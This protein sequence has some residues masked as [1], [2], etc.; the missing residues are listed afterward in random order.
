MS[1]AVIS[2]LEGEICK[3]NGCNGIMSRPFG[4]GHRQ[5]GAWVLHF[6][7]GMKNGKKLRNKKK[8]RKGNNICM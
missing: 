7:V 4:Q 8:W 1:N 6:F 5:F 2:L 3:A